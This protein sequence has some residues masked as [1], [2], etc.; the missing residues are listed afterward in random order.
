MKNRINQKK[1]RL[2]L[3]EVL[4]SRRIGLYDF[5]GKK[6]IVANSGKGDCLMRTKLQVYLGGK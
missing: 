3:S 1:E 6:K 2:C 4:C 5:P